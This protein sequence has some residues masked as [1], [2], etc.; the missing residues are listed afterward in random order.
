MSSK[1]TT[2]AILVLVLGACAVAWLSLTDRISSEEHAQSPDVCSDGKVIVGV[3]DGYECRK[4]LRNGDIWLRPVG[5]RDCLVQI[6]SPRS[7]PTGVARSKRRAFLASS[8]ASI[9][10]RVDASLG[11]K[12]EHR[13]AWKTYGSNIL[14]TDS[15][16]RSR[17]LSTESG[18]LWSGESYCLMRIARPL[19][20]LGL[21]E[22]ALRLII[23]SVRIASERAP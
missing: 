14:L 22:S 12:I 5:V 11:R 7:F 21:D 9:D 1:R 17:S 23:S 6:H 2:L 4:S 13:Y 8:L 16:R 10:A 15:P 19:K 20:G 3:P 18:L